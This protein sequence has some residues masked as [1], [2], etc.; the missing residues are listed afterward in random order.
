MCSISGIINGDIKNLNKMILCQAHRAPDESGIYNSKNIFIGMGRLKIIDLDSKNLCPYVDQDIVLSYNGEIF[1]FI[2]LK[3]ELKDY[4]WKFKTE[5]DTEVLAFAWKQWGYRMFDKI[6]GMFA[7]CIYEKK[8]NQII[9]ARDVAGE[10]PLYYLRKNNKF[11]FSSEA[12]AI[13]L[14]ANP[15]FTNNE[16]YFAFQHCLSKTLWKNL[17]QI[18]SAHYLVL[19]VN[20]LNFKI[21]EY[22]KFKKKKIDLKNP[23]EQLDDLLKKSLDLR[24]RS[25]VALGLY[26][27]KGMDSSLL[28][29]LK[30]F[31]YK[32]Y[33]NDQGNY[34]IDF[35]KQIKKIAYHLDFPVGSL[36]SYPLWKL[37]E[38]ASKKV[39]V[40]ISGEGADELFG[41][42]VRY[43][44]IAQEW[45]LKNKFTSYKYLF[46]KFYDNYLSSFAKI[47]TRIDDIELVKKTIRPYF[48]IF[49][50]PINAMGFVDFKIIMPSLL[51]M[52]DR[53]AG[54]HGL[55]NRCPFLDKNIIEFAFS[56]PPN[57]KINDL[58]QKILIRR[59]LEKYKKRSALKIEKKG[60]TITFNKWFKISDWSRDYYFKML[61]N[62]WKKSNNL[63]K[64]T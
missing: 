38:S 53:M 6:N 8:K 37:A 55:E 29:A 14:A 33:F 4:N 52:G 1:N 15:E 61:D 11:Y 43:L 59:L 23:E 19:N 3:K 48:E 24:S 13:V 5:S 35:L 20:T 27:S 32:F 58:Q 51:Q 54:A 57:L 9:L 22:W 47:T 34:K 56:L 46:N 44:P 18:P 10:K 2:E 63:N 12:K 50:D 21:F 36:S 16:T 42:Y 26:Y 62:E 30:K 40:I 45:Q 64:K 31:K 41:G 17:F 49:D 60:L 25:D 39:K 28:L 7:F